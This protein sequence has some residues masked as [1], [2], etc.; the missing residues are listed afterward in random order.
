MSTD[1]PNTETEIE[2][3]LGE[4]YTVQVGYDVDGNPL[5]AT[6]LKRWPTHTG[7]YNA[8]GTPTKAAQSP[9]GRSSHST[10]WPQSRFLGRNS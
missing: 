3:D 4:P 2:L 8:D 7:G 5:F 6:R 9:H 10:S 1:K